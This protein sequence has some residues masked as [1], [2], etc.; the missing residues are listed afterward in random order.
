MT[1][2]KLTYHTRRWD[3][4]ATLTMRKTAAGWHI[5]N[6]SING[7]TDTEGSPILEQNLHQ[8]NVRFPHDVGSFLGF[9]WGQLNSGDIDDERTQEMIDELGEWITTCETSQP[10]WCPWNA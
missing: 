1:N 8:D 5:S 10:V 3:N 9:I 4:S 2:F 7:D 6:I